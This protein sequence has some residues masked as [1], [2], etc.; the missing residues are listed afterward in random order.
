MWKERGKERVAIGK[1]RGDDYADKT[2]Q[3]MKKLVGASLRGH[4]VCIALELLTIYKGQNSD[5]TSEELGRHQLYQVIKV[6]ITR[7]DT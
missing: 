7:N 5:L 4:R 2:L 3:W 6:N 1:H